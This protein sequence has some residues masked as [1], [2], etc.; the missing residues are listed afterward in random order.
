MLEKRMVMRRTVS[1]I[2]AKA[3]LVCVMISC[4]LLLA[5]CAKTPDGGCS[6]P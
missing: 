2:A 3:L 5:S 1:S 4:L 6:L